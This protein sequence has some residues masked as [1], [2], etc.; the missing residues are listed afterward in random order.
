MGRAGC[1][2]RPPQGAGE[3]THSAR[4]STLVRLSVAVA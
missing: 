1:R 4:L 3:H 2:Q